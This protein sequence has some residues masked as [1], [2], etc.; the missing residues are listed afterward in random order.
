M[1]HFAI[2][3]THCYKTAVFLTFIHH[4]C[5]C[6]FELGFCHL[7]LMTWHWVVVCCIDIICVI[8]W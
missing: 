5:D 7:Y 1:C 6:F 2:G 4:S 8:H 3:L